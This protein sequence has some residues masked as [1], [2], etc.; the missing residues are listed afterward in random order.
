MF[1]NNFH[2]ARPFFLRFSHCNF[3]AIL[4]MK[5]NN[6]R[7]AFKIFDNLSKSKKCEKSGEILIKK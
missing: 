5:I 6:E 4:R 3:K 1:S 7:G 2:N